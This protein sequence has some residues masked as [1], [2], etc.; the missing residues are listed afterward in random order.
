LNALA[1]NHSSAIKIFHIRTT[2]TSSIVA[3]SA[4]FAR[5]VE[6]IIVE[7]CIEEKRH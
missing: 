3:N 4:L 1:S 7:A 6:S 5:V 2:S